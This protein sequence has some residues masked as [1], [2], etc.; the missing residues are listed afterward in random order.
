MKP[1]VF[2]LLTAGIVLS[3]GNRQNASREQ[4]N[5]NQNK[6]S[7]Q[8]E[9]AV[10]ILQGEKLDSGD[11]YNIEQVELVGNSLAFTVSYSG[12]CEDH[13]FSLLNDGSIMK[14]MPPQTNLVL[15]HEANGDKCRSMITEQL[16]FNLEPLQSMASGTIVLRVKDFDGKFTY[17]Y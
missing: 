10:Q 1:F 11:A 13:A 8:E 5:L 9:N 12:G 15:K 3:C 6:K 7:V 16:I 2:I 14:S 4:G 17:N